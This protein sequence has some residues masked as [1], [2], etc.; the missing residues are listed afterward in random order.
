[1]SQKVKRYPSE[2]IDVT[3]DIKRCI[4]AA[5][6]VRGL[7][8]VFDV[9]KRPWV[10]PANASAD[11]VAEVIGRCPTGA[12]KFERKDGGTAESIPNRN[13]IIITADG[14]LHVR[15]NVQIEVGGETMAETRLALC[16][17]GQSANKPFCD[18]AHKTAD[19]SDAVQASVAAPVEMD[20]S[21]ELAIMA[22]SNGPLLLRGNFELL[23]AD[24]KVVFRGEKAALCRCGGSANK[25]FCD[26]T[27]KV[28]G[29]TAE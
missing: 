18:N 17:C 3:Y 28:I 14:P 12:L 27:H 10:Q 11:A 19:F 15:G 5:E 7:P 6:C 13:Q 22:A 20:V 24:G 23:S 21:G 16:R 9:E 29:F 2:Q 25:P 26:G 8:A 1:M 4:H